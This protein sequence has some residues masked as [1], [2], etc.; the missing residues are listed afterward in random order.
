MSFGDR[1]IGET[2]SSIKSLGGRH[3][4]EQWQEEWPTG[5]NKAGLSERQYQ[6]TH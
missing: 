4:A 2:P 1:A 6:L 5:R 3:C